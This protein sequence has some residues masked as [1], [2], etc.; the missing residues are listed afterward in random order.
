MADYSEMS[1]GRKLARARMS[2]LRAGVSKSGKNIKLAFKYFELEDILQIA[3][4]IFDRIGLINDMVITNESATAKVYNADHMEETPIVF[5][6]P[7]GRMDQIISKAGNL[8]TNDIQSLGGSVT[9]LRRYLWMLVLEVI[10]PDEIDPNL[11]DEAADEVTSEPVLKLK[12]KKSEA[13]APATAEERKEAKKKLTS[14][15]TPANEEQV[16]ELK[17]LCKQLIATDEKQEDF[18]NKIAL[19]TDAFT[20]LSSDV[21][22]QLIEKIKEILSNYESVEK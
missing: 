17:T 9:Y 15:E 16:T 1:V 11:G 21:C 4:P 12:Q 14:E 10:E 6:I 2:F 13:K 7:Y 5:S 20:N 22:G 19:K 8:V 18:V 3:I